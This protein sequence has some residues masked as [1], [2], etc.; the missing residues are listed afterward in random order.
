[1]AHELSIAGFESVYLVS[2]ISALC[3]SIS[4]M[5]RQPSRYEICTRAY[6]RLL[7]QP[8]KVVTFL[9]ATALVTFAAPYSGDATWDYPDSI[10]IS[11]LTYIVA[12]WS[13]GV[14]FQS[15][16]DNRLDRRLFVAM[17]LFLSPCWMYDAYILIRDH[18]YP[19]TWVSNLVLS[20]GIIVLAGLFWNLAWR[21]GK[22]AHFAFSATPWLDG[23]VTPLKALI[24]PAMMIGLPVVGMIWWF[25]HDALLAAK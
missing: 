4:L 7:L 24:L 21:P 12:P 9:M 3:L 23:G 5:A 11:C 19:A 16:R 14:A 10:A 22:G 20:G 15:F 17:F 1:M 2:W 6:W 8:W 18:A 25:V 13:I